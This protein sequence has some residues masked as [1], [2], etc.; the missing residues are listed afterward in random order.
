MSIN[1]NTSAEEAILKAAEEV[2]LSKGFAMSTTTAI[3]KL[4]GVNQALLHYYFRTKENLFEAVFLKKLQLVT[5]AMYE[6][7]GKEGIPLMDKIKM[8]IETQFDFVQSNP[9]LPFL[10]VSEVAR[11]PERSERMGVMVGKRVQQALGKL[12]EE[13]D[14]AHEEGKIRKTSAVNLLLSVISQNVFPFLIRPIFQ[15]ITNM[16]DGD[17]EKLMAS[18]KEENVAFIINSLKIK[19]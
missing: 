12:Q 19:S 11:A 4:A 2:F 3:A 15:A 6:I 9:K 18:K 13:L 17:F 5:V 16:P 14:K 7:L 8:Q 1:R 10:V